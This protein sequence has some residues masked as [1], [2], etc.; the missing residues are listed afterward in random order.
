MDMIAEIMAEMIS[1]S[2]GNIHDIDHLIRVWTYAR[3]IA[4]LESIDDQTQRITEIAAIMHDIGCPLC[5]EKYGT[6]QKTIHSCDLYTGK[7]PRTRA[8]INKTVKAGLRMQPGFYRVTD[9]RQ[10]VFYE[11]VL[12]LFYKLDFI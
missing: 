2:K 6:V 5:R 9:I 12:L 1:Y 8:E 11:T 7:K 4:S 3:T 10:I